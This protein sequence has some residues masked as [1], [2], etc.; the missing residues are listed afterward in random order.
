[1]FNFCSIYAMKNHSWRRRKYC[2]IVAHVKINLVMRCTNLLMWGSWTYYPGIKL[3]S[4]VHKQA[5]CHEA[6]CWKLGKS[7]SS[8][9][10]PANHGLNV[11]RG[12]KCPLCVVTQVL[13]IL[14]PTQWCIHYLVVSTFP[15][16]RNW[17]KWDPTWERVVCCRQIGFP[18]Y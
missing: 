9:Q 16:R 17:N 4:W 5:W 13:P 11:E 8:R 2:S 15:E 12:L 6:P 14:K 7:S 18:V 3:L 10:H 1:M